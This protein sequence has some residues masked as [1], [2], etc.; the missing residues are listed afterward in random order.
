TVKSIIVQQ[1]LSYNTAAGVLANGAVVASTTK[2]V[3]YVG[4]P[5]DGS[6]T[7]VVNVQSSG[8]YN[9]FLKYISGD[10]IVRPLKIDINNIDTGII[11]YPPVTLNWTVSAAKIFT[12]Q[13]NLNLGNNIIKFHGNGTDYC[14]DLGTF[15]LNFISPLTPTI[16]SSTIPAVSSNNN[17][18]TVNTTDKGTDLN[19]FNFAGIWNGDVS[20]VW[21]QDVN[22]TFKINF[23]GIE[24]S[25]VGIK[26]PRHGIYMISIDNNTPVEINGYSNIRTQPQTI[27]NSGILLNGNHSLQFK[28]KSKDAQINYA[29]IN[30]GDITTNTV[31]NNTIPTVPTIPTYSYNVANGV[32]RDGVILDTVAK[33]ATYIGGT[34]DGS[35][36]V[37]INVATTETYN[38]V[39]SY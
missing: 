18:I 11:Y 39:V 21:S 19:K 36:T 9:L 12:V 14:P 4:G 7:V 15:S 1:T 6:S 3:A 28:M 25:L 2:F 23:K 24:I 32:L 35:S 34:S 13:V 33:L 30:L 22:S 37:G 16:P 17:F 8:V 31:A 29:V 27:Y 38:L 10:G 20:E 5:S 26:D